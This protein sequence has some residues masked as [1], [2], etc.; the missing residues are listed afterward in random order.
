MVHISPEAKKNEK[1]TDQTENWICTQIFKVLFI[2]LK[3]LIILIFK[4]TK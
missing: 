2:Y 4:I 1:K 3:V